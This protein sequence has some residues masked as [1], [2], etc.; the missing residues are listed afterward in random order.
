VPAFPTT[1]TTP[2]E[3]TKDIE[4]GAVDPLIF[5]LCAVIGDVKVFVPLKL[6]LFPLAIL[7]TS[8]ALDEAIIW[9]YNSPEVVSV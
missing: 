2:E 4:V 5:I 8:V 7:L 1:E 3:A 9:L 6:K